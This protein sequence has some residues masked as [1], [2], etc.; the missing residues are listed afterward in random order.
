MRI[1]EIKACIVCPYLNQTNGYHRV[2][3]CTHLQFRGGINDP[4][5]KENIIGKLKKD[6]SL[7]KV[8]HKR[9][10]SGCPLK[11]KKEN[12]NVD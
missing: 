5:R 3:R 11:I 7:P 10:A 2:W 4:R 12:K 6:G 9:V 8:A 1:I